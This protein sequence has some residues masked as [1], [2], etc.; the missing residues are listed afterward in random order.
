MVGRK[1]DQCTLA[2]GWRETLQEVLLECPAELAKLGCG[3]LIVR[4]V[5]VREVINLTG[6]GP[7]V[8][9][10]VRVG[11]H[12]MAQVDPQFGWGEIPMHI[13]ILEKHL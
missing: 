4:V 5:V 1:Q 10:L 8:L 12:Q 9:S 3:A 13:H 7:K 11:F 2:K 6:I